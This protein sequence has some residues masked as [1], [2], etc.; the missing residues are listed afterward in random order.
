VVK[1]MA[2]D[3]IKGSRA[4]AAKLQNIAT[5]ANAP[6]PAWPSGR[7]VRKDAMSSPRQA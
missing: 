5:I 4:S 2:F 1:A 7:S 6:R 3:S